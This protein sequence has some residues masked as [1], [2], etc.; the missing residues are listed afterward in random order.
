MADDDA[1]TT[2]RNDQSARLRELKTLSSGGLKRDHDTDL[3]LAFED[4]QSQIAGIAVRIDEQ[5][6]LLKTQRVDDTTMLQNVS[7]TT[8]QRIADA[9]TQAAY[10]QYHLGD[11]LVQKASSMLGSA[12]PVAHRKAGASHEQQAS[13]HPGAIMQ[14]KP[15]DTVAAPAAAANTIWVPRAVRELTPLNLTVAIEHLETLSWET[16][17]SNLGGEKWSPGFYLVTNPNSDKAI[18]NCKAYWLLE[19]INEPFAPSLPGVHGAKLTA[20]YREGTNEH[21]EPSED[22]FHDIP[23]F[24]ALASSDE[25]TYMGHYRQFRFSDRLS[26]DTMENVPVTV[27]EYWSKQLADPDRPDWV[28]AALIEH[29]WPKPRY[30][31]PMPTDEATTTP[32]T[33]ATA[34]SSSSHIVLERRV[35]EGVR[36][37]VEQ[38]KEWD[39][40]SHRKVGMLTPINMLESF[41]K[42]DSEEEP[43]L[44]LRWEYMQCLRWD[45]AFYMRMVQY[46]HNI[47][48]HGRER[49]KKKTKRAE[50]EIVYALPTH[51]HVTKPAV[52]EVES[53]SRKSP[54][55]RGTKPAVGGHEKNDRTPPHLRKR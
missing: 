37:Y 47:N 18:N 13:L 34:Q 26:Y 43:G 19:Q 17:T 45:D 5:D 29:F 32:A 33:A 54:R 16:I 14:S 31:G 3:R 38:L 22:A 1:A 41:Q 24:V 8:T 55:L 42:A 51:P 52:A 30:A 12:S 7:Q 39:R 53:S 49:S 50:A 36:E 6:L 4:L 23:V 9:F 35:K 20:F 28:T 10:E 46:K 44:R 40:E 25:Y 48:P 15:E 2:D 27:L 11:L 21:D